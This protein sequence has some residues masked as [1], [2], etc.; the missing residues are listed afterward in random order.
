MV[1][2]HKGLAITAPFRL[3]TRRSITSL[4]IARM[5]QIWTE[6]KHIIA[7]FCHPL[8]AD[9]LPARTWRPP[10]S[11]LHRNHAHPTTSLVLK[12][13]ETAE[14]SGH[15]PKIVCRPISRTVPSVWALSHIAESSIFACNTDSPCQSVILP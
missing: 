7:K 15:L 11:S 1:P 6:R 8:A 4:Q 14:S 12:T 2:D 13:I 3:N 9:R 10:G 5:L